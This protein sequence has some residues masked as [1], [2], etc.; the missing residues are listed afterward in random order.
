MGR[1]QKIF[2]EMS[3][4]V[5]QSKPLSAGE[6]LGCTAPV[7]RGADCLVFVADGRFHLEAGE[8]GSAPSL[9][10]CRLHYIALYPQ[11]HS[12]L[13]RPRQRVICCGVEMKL[14]APPPPLPAMIQNPLLKAYRYDPYGKVITAEGYDT[15]RMKANRLAAIREA[16]GAQVFGVILGTLGRQGSPKIFSRLRALLRRHGRRC[17]LFLMAELNP[18][19]LAAIAHIQAWVQVSCPRLSIDWGAGFVKV[20]SLVHVF[21]CDV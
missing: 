2:P 6:T 4:A 17:V 3:S 21:C 1:L 16:A 20:R 12:C 14:T 13:Y 7:I 10:H 8:R 19:K 11:H 15:D 5:P 18:A 9:L